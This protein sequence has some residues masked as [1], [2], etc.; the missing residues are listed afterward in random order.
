[1]HDKTFKIWGDKAFASIPLA[2]NDAPVPN[3]H[4]SLIPFLFRPVRKSISCFETRVNIV[5]KWFCLIMFKQEGK[6]MPFP[7]VKMVIRFFSGTFFRCAN[8]IKYG[9][10]VTL[11][12][13]KRFT[14]VYS[15]IKNI[16]RLWSRKTPSALTFTRP[17]NK[18]DFLW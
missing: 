4:Q 5:G 2:L 18:Y 8:L 12:W 10:Y 7:C 17:G 16:I 13:S 3:C 6:K 11:S 15:Y 14:V 9:D 1:M